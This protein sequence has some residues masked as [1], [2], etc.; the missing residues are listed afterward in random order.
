[1]LAEVERRAQISDVI[2]IVTV[3][4]EEYDLKLPDASISFALLVN[5]IHEVD[6]KERMLAEVSRILKSKGKLGIVD[7]E[8][9]DMEVGPPIEHRIGREEVKNLLNCT[10]FEILIEQDFSGIFYGITA[11]KK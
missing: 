11:L 1:M 2:N 9:T 6:N 4:T 10:S 3:Q 5:V 8:K 7:W